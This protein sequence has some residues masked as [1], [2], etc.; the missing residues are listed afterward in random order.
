MKPLSQLAL[1]APLT[2]EPWGEPLSQLVLTAPLTG[3][4]WGEPLSQLVL[5]ASLTGEPLERSAK[6]FPLKGGM[7]VLLT[8][9]YATNVC[10]KIH[11]P[12]VDRTVENGYNKDARGAAGRRLTLS[13]SVFEV[14]AELC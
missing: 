14:I 4:P 3:E 9:G 8:R 2:G 10:K 11:P 6:L 1:T 12:P 13:E 7:S 5:T